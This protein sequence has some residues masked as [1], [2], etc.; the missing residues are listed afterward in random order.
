MNIANSKGEN[1]LLFLVQ[2]VGR[3]SAEQRQYRPARTRT[4]GIAGS[5]KGL[6]ADVEPDMPEHDLEPPRFSRRALER[7]LSDWS[8]VKAMLLSGHKEEASAT[9][10]LSE[11]QLY[12]QSQSGTT[13]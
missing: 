3:Q 2:T 5:R 6:T 12:L 8:S 9:N 10:S 13:L 4:T 1:I 11:D 7:L